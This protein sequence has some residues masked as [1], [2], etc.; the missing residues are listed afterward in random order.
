MSVRSQQTAGRLV[1]QETALRRIATLVARGSSPVEIFTA[2]TDEASRVIG[3]EATGLLRFEADETATL[4]AQSETPWEPPPLGTQFTLD[5]ENVVAQV[6]RTGHPV[7]VDDWTDATGAVT[8]MAQVLGVR[9]AVATPVVVDGRL[10]G[11]MIAA[12]SQS[13]PLPADTESRLDQFT[14]LVATGIANAEARGSLARLVEEQAAL[15]QVA[16]FVAEQPSPDEVFT[17]VTESVGRLL[18][19]D[20][21]AMHVFGADGTATSIAGWS[22]TG[23]I[24][25]IGTRLPLDGDSAVARVFTTGAAARIDTYDGVEGGT[26]DVARGLSLRSTVGAPILVR[27]QLWGALMA[28][29]RGE[30]PLPDD[31]ETRIAAFTELVATAV[32]NAQAREDL[33]QLVDEQA[34]LRR[35]ATLVAGGTGPEEVFSAVA[36]EVAGLFGSDVSAIVRFEDDGT[37]TVLG[38]VG[39]PHTPGGRVTLDPGYPVHQV[40]ETGASA[41]FDTDDPSAAQAE[42]LARTL[43]I[44][45]SVASPIVVE[46]ELWGAITAASLQGRLTANAERRLTEFTELVATAVANAEAHRAMHVFADEQA[47]L[48]R[49]ATLVAASAAPGALFAAV[50]EEIALVLGADATMLARAEADGS[51]VVVGTWAERTPDIGTRIARGG[52]NLTSIVLDTGRPARI[53]SYDEATGDGAELARSQGLRSAVGAPIHVEGRIWGLVLA[54]TTT[55]EPLPPD[56]EKRV[57]GFT[58]LLATAIAN[59]QAQ[60][61]LT[62]LAEQQAALRRVATLVARRGAPEAVFTAVAEE[63]GGL[64]GADLAGLVRIAG[65]D[66]VTV[67]AG[68]PSGPHPVGA[69]LSIDP[70]FVVHAVRETGRPA[71]FETDDPFA[72]GM[73]DL[74]RDLG[75]RSAVASPILVEGALWGAVILASF[76]ASF[77]AETEQRLDEFTELVATAISNATA[78]AE[79]VASRARLVTAGDEALRRVERDLHD[80]TQQ[81]LLA[82]GLDLQRVR[83]GI[84][85]AQPDASS[86]LERVGDDLES[87]VEEVRELSRGLHPA[88]LSRSGLAPALRALARRSPIDVDLR[89]DVEER[90][91]KAIETAVYFVVSEALANAIKH[92]GATTISIAVVRDGEQVLATISDD[93]V[94]GAVAGRGSGLTG[95]RD[96][97]EALGGRF[98]LAGSPGTTVS[99]ELPATPP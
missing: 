2:V 60:A 49:V 67:M 69:Q 12:T 85:D 15:R 51:A 90:P 89:V 21:S 71:R 42:S 30:Q 45:S 13:E 84:A 64:L 19:A 24:V 77:P 75:V 35:V 99:V 96:R 73:P 16:M 59:A 9:S 98:A 32:S 48:R 41:R 23:P 68:P 3:S 43:G 33:E 63:A 14:G 50:T 10:W 81:R 4:V 53:D 38:D 8:A 52:T 26:A 65:D 6:F 70:G 83:A 17:A 76:G 88:Q 79:L 86:E 1:E 39:G 87:V 66:T 36:A 34:A 37:A 56:A 28:A 44:R 92:S 72:Q 62:S 5:G 29:T 55:D 22:E 57:A 25:P 27:G 11:T 94:G 95:M 78:R 80:G 47:S 82:I 91:A 61:D 7:R 97:V 46:G 93:G 58:E 74:V 54:G 40:R 18:G 20:L 31:A